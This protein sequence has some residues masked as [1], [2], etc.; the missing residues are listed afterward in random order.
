MT[1]ENCCCELDLP[2]VSWFLG[3]MFGS[4]F[5]ILLDLPPSFGFQLASQAGFPLRLGMMLDVRF[6]WV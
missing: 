1:R 3:Y 6:A 4:V 2:R 5:L